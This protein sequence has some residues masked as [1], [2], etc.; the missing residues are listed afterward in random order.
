[1]VER[2]LKIREVSKLSQEKFAEKLGLSRN[3]INQVEN[4]KK[5]F[6]DRTISDICKK[7]IIDGKTINENWLKTGEG[8]MLN[9]LTTNQEIQLF[10]NNIMEQTNE[11]FCKRFV[12][13]LSK[14]DEEDWKTIEKIVNELSEEG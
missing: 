12:R 2:I 1:M 3:F 14:L 4:G 7:I 10:A 5:N 11:S 9:K 6:S 13:A 8:I